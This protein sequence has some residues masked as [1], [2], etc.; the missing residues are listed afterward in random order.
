MKTVT[1]EEHFLTQSF[2]DATHGMGADP[3]AAMFGLQEKLL[4]L[5]AGRIRAMDEGGVDVQVLSLAALGLD[6]LT[7]SNEAA[8]LRDVHDEL[9]AAV[10]RHPH[11]FRAFCTPPLMQPDAALGE[12]ERCLA[13]PGFVGVIVDGTTH[14]KFLDAPEFFPVLELIAQKGVPLYIHPAPPPPPVFEAY[15]AGLPGESSRLLSIAGWGWHTETAIHTLRLILSGTLDRLPQ[16]KVIIGH[17]GEALPFF[18]ARTNAVFSSQTHLERS[19]AETLKEQV[20]ITTSGVFTRPPFDCARAVLG[21][22]RMM[23]SVDYPFSPNTRGQEFLRTL[24]LSE[25][26]R[27]AFTWGTAAS[28]LRLES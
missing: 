20:W 3:N 13:L 25:P 7:A 6:K 17:M 4:D 15:Y 9:A 18:L 23:Y 11:R 8:V 19:V 21:L 26:E 2:L 16:L 10:A 24:D 5:D 22:D 27:A 1:L 14:G 28:L 12:I